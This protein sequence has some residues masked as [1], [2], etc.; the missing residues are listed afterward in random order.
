MCSYTNFCESNNNETKIK[1]KTYDTSSYSPFLSL[2]C[3]WLQYIRM[4]R[5][6]HIFVHRR[7]D[8]YGTKR[9]TMDSPEGR[10]GNLMLLETLILLQAIHLIDLCWCRKMLVYV[11][12]T[13]KKYRDSFEPRY[14][15]FIRSF[16]TNIIVMMYIRIIV[17][18]QSN[19]AINT[20]CHCIW[21]FFL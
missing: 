5:Q 3:H 1:K 4:I 6:H 17:I 8:Y 7:N 13:F 10:D 21:L 11:S 15:Y 18:Q 2:A 9:D 16:K 20:C 14:S 19:I 12:S